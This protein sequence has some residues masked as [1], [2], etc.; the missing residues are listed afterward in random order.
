[1]RFI[2]SQQPTSKQKWL[3]RSGGWY[4]VGQE[5]LELVWG[6]NLEEFGE[7]T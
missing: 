5:P 1:M 4:S 3:W 2:L 7:T 6:G